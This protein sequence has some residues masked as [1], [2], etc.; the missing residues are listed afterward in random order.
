MV[1]TR[2]LFVMVSRTDTGIAKIIRAVS[3][4]P[5]NHVSVTLDPS[6]RRWYSFARYVQDAPLYGGFVCES[7]ERFCAATGDAR[8]R[9]FRVEIPEKTAS[10]LEE[11]QVLAGQ[12]DSGLIYNH[13]DAAAGVLG[14]HFPVPS[15][16]TCLSFACELLDRRHLT[17]QSLCDDLAPYR[18]YEGS[19]NALTPVTENRDEPYFS[20]LGLI[21]GTSLSALQLAKLTT[22]SVIHGFN[23]YMANRFHRTAQ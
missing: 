1:K 22:R 8:V 4:Y 23:S 21:Q 14:C 11:L 16:H 3:R 13:F 15:S 12:T 19:L 2:S 17:I 10:R 6:L 5:Y 9:I 7:V 20:R 18:I